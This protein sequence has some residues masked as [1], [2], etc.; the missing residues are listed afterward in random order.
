MWRHSLPP[1][2]EYVILNDHLG[3]TLLVKLSQAAGQ[4]KCELYFFWLNT[5]NDG[6]ALDT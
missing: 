1:D 4:R 2:R 6:L 3:Y 5:G